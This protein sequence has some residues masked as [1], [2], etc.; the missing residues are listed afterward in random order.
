MF[1]WLAEPSPPP[2]VG[3]LLLPG[4]SLAELAL[5]RTA[6]ACLQQLTGPAAGTCPTLS[7]DGQPV[8]SD[9]GLPVP[10][11]GALTPAAL[12]TLSVLLVFASGLP[13]ALPPSD[14]LVVTLSAALHP[15]RVLGGVHAGAFWLAAAGLLGKTESRETG[16]HSPAAEKY[17]AK[18]KNR[19]QNG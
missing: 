1:D 4:F 2:H 18:Q 17:G 13:A 10:A 3:L 9:L 12:D 11:D 14:A 16:G 7:V 15:R 19:A 5:W 8:L 6:H